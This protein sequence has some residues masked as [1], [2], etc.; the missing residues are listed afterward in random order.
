LKYSAGATAANVVLSAAAGTITFDDNSSS[1]AT[2]TLV[3][4]NVSGTV[5]A[6][7]ASGNTQSTPGQITLTDTLSSADTIKTLN[8]SLTSGATVVNSGLDK[9]VTFNAAGSTGAITATINESTLTTVIGG[10]GNDVLDVTFATD[11][12]SATVPSASIEGGAGNDSITVSGTGTGKVTVSGGEGNDTASIAGTLLLTNVTLDGGAGTDKLKYTA[13]GTTMTAGEFALVASQ[14]SGFER[15]EFVTTTSLDASKVSQ[16]TILDAGATTAAFTK[17]A[18]A[19]T[20]NTAIT[21]ALTSASYI[22]KGTAA[23][24]AAGLTDTS[25]GGALTVNATGSSKT[26][27]VNASSATVNVGNIVSTSSGSAGDQSASS[28]TIEGDV[29]TLT[30]NMTAGSNFVQAP[31]ADVISTVTI[32]PTIVY[33]GASSSNPYAENGNLTSVT[34][35]GVGGA[36]IDNSTNSNSVASSKLVTVDASNFGGVQSSLAGA[37]A[38]LP[39]GGLTYTGNLYLAETVTLGSGKD[40]ITVKST[41]DKMDTVNGFTL[42]ANADGTLNANKSDVLVVTTAASTSVFA[43]ITTGLTGTTL[44][45]VLTQVAAASTA[46]ADDPAIFQFAGNTYVYVDGGNDLLDA[47]D[48]VIQL[49][50]LYDLDLL[51]LSLEA[52]NV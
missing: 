18:D 28:I 29:K 1:T 40:S 43:K 45:A 47:D 50:G 2:T 37:N 42:V 51:K 36:T 16:F 14:T 10:S 4:A 12:A 48:T 30:V 9:L 38:G 49:T 17:L 13:A 41:Y 52:N 34:L 33:V 19:Q 7:A 39:L 44:G 15:A 11:P 26:V 27:D 3:T 6:N 32:V 22:G 46:T 24:I 20:V 23:A 5:K 35:T 8:L 31:S 25:Y 21:A